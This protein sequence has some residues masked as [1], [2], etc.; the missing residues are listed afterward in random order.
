MTVT[1]L[2]GLSKLKKEY[3][4]ICKQKGLKAK[5]IFKSHPDIWSI[6]ESSD[7]IV[8]ITSNINHNTAKVAKTVSK[9]RGIPLFLCHKSSISSF[10][11]TI[12]MCSYLCDSCSLKEN[13]KIYQA[14]GRQND[15]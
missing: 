2:G 5:F 14:G 12:N 3:S 11:D 13:C 9:E 1:V 8:L 4:K 6:L 10:K 15:N 7:A